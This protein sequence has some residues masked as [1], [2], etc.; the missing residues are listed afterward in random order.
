MQ[1]TRQQLEIAIAALEAQRAS[2]GDAVVD[3]VLGPM[4]EQLA[5]L[6]SAS[7]QAVAT[8]NTPP[9]QKLKQVSVLFL[10]IVGSTNLS[11]HLDP[12][13]VYALVDG[14]LERCTRVVH[15]HGGRV[16]QYAGDNLLA[17]FGAD[18]AQEDDAERA[19]HCGLVLLEEGRA[20]EQRVQQ[21]HGHAGCNLRVG[22]H[23]GPV[24][25]GGG[26]DDE[27]SIRGLTVNIAA[28]MEQT[29]PPGGLRISYDTWLPVPGVFD[30]LAQPPLQVKGRDE[31][32]VT[33]LVQR[34][35]PRAFRI[36]ARGIEDVATPLVGR[37]AEMGQLV[38]L[39]HATTTDRTL[40]AATIV[41]DPGLGKSRLMRGPSCSSAAQPGAKA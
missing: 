22:I 35:K 4:R 19:V 16:L 40:H 7:N 12:E 1:D 17:A 36:A 6:Q 8:T 23:T 20:Y 28:R 3:A 9:A 5:R 32:L 11:Q 26:V 14:V 37:D 38:A 41:G 15:S 34:A 29:A 30:V 2:L 33:Y 31:P 13:D 21:K 24:L 27:G 10:D 25:L 18:Q 39:L